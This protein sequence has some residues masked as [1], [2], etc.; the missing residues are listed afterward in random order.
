MI[1]ARF[2]TGIGTGLETSKSAGIKLN[3]PTHT[4]EA[5]SS[6]A[7]PYSSESESSRVSGPP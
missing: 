1:V 2:V 6:A 7:S 3:C 5:A 4:T